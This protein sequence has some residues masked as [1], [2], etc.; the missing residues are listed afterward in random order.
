[1]KTIRLLVTK[2]KTIRV[3]EHVGSSCILSMDSWLFYKKDV[4]C[5][6]A[7]ISITWLCGWSGRTC[8]SQ[9][10]LLSTDEV[11]SAADEV[12][13]LWRIVIQLMKSNRCSNA[14]TTSNISKKWPSKVDSTNYKYFKCSCR[15]SC[16]DSIFKETEIA[17]FLRSHTNL[18]KIVSKFLDLP[19][20]EQRCKA[21]S[22][23][24][25]RITVFFEAYMIN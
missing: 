9:T 14:A 12:D 22:N 16:S 18:D 21:Y 23:T 6:N 24:A 19:Q 20:P 2:C 25:S 5:L 4:K 17:S 15:A 3:R 13:L 1:M 8:R 11:R 7:I 10:Y